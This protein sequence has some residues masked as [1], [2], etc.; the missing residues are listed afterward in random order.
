MLIL[1]F[2]IS[3]VESEPRVPVTVPLR[4]YENYMLGADLSVGTP[5]QN[6]TLILDTLA[7]SSSIFNN[8]IDF[9]PSGGKKDH[10]RPG[11]S[12]TFIS[13]S[14]FFDGA[15]VP[16][17]TISGR[18]AIDTFHI[19]GSI[20]VS[21]QSF[22]LI[23]Y[24]QNWYKFMPGDGVLGLAT[25][26]HTYEGPSFL[27]NV[28]TQTGFS[29]ITLW[30]DIRNTPGTHPLGGQLT[31]GSDDPEHCNTTDTVWVD[32]NDSVVWDFR[33][34]ALRVPQL[35]QT[36]QL[37]ERLTSNKFNMAKFELWSD[38]GGRYITGPNTT[39]QAIAGWLGATYDWQNDSYLIFC[40]K[41]DNGPEIVFELDKGQWLT[42][43]PQHYIIQENANQTTCDFVFRSYNDSKIKTKDSWIEREHF[44]KFGQILLQSHCV[45]LQ[46]ATASTAKSKIGFSRTLDYN[47]LRVHPNPKVQG[48]PRET[49]T[50]EG[51]LALTHT[52][53]PLFYVI[54]AAVIAIIYV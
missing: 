25:D 23:T 6:V 19:N 47:Y 5:P 10:Y 40:E 39:V 43:G 49:S 28:L 32:R 14:T 12:S 36:L 21:N 50:P 8:S 52:P 48:E 38:G 24:Q 9:G 33:L 13:T 7:K 22:E 11:E 16:N 17:M 31:F 45:Q 2:I 27:F 51:N 54:F 1:Q 3:V 46:M 4:Q 42:L 53:F 26:N 35:K 30:I 29:T 20:P 41:A 15:A 18:V 44:W 34:H 37:T